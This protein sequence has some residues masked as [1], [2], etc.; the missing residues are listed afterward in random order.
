[1]PLIAYASSWKMQTVAT[2]WCLLTITRKEIR[3]SQK[4]NVGTFLFRSS[5]VW[6]RSTIFV[7][8][9]ET[10]NARM[11][12]SPRRASSSLE[13]WTSPESPKAEWCEHK[14]EPLIMPALRSG[15]TCP[16]ITEVTSG[17]L[18]VSS[19]KWSWRCPRSGHKLWKGST[20]RCFLA[21]MT[22]FMH[23]LLMIW[24]KC[25]EAAFRFVP[26]KDQSA[27]EYW[28]CQDSWTTSRE[29]LTIFRPWSPTR[30]T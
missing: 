6:R 10:S 29:L 25:F 22:P 9:I 2:F 13:T 7:S 1:M 5:E 24:R 30:R 16:M 17:A 4:S 20:Q 11:C 3:T 18:A 23:T 27:I 21:S 8:A 14:P 26:L 15:K 12:S 19:M 28:I